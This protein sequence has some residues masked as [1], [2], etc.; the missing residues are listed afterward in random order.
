L[1][2]LGEVD[3]PDNKSILELVEEVRDILDLHEEDDLSEAGKSSLGRAFNKLLKG[4]KSKGKAS[5][6]SIGRKFNKL[7]KGGG[8]KSK[9][10]YRTKSAHNPFRRLKKGPLGPGPRGSTTRPGRKRNYWKC[11]CSGYKCLC[12]GS[13]GEEKEVRIDRAY[14]KSYNLIYRRYR[15]KNPK[16]YRGGRW[17]TL[18][19]KK[20]GKK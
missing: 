9:G 2:V 18:K 6:S 20:K 16:L 5:K 15:A 7:L 10:K 11:R 12:R 19:A 14:K 17:K 13:K 3:M 1:E 8:K 4:K